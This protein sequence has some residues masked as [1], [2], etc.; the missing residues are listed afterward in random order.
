VLRCVT[1]ACPENLQGK[2]REEFYRNK[3]QAEGVSKKLGRFF[4]D[5]EKNPE[6]LGYM[7]GNINIW[8]SRN[9]PYLMEAS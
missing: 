8:M 2:T 7:I 1:G 6:K 5:V 9:Y 3:Y 4:D